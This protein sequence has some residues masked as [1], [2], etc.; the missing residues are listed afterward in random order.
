MSAPSDASE[1]PTSP[2]VRALVDRVFRERAGAMVATLTRILGA[3]HLDLAEDVVQDALLQALRVWSFEGPPSNPSAWL[4]QVA[5]NRALDALRRD[6]ILQSKEPELRRWAEEAQAGES[7]PRDAAAPDELGD[8]RLRLMFVCCHDALSFDA[9]VALTLKT[10]GGF[11]VAEIARAFLAE[12]ATIAQRLVRAKRRIQELALPFEVPPPAELPPRLDAVLDVLYLLFNEGYSATSGEELI[13]PE[14]VREAIRLAELLAEFPPTRTPKVHALLALMLLQGARLPARTDEAGDLLLLAD[15]DRA[16]WDRTMIQRGF[17]AL[18]RAAAGESISAFHLEA[19]IAASHALAPSLAATDWPRILE[20]YDQL[21][22]LS[23]SPVVALNRVVAVAHVDGPAAAMEQLAPLADD[24]SL[25]LYS[26]LHATRGELLA[27]LG[28]KCEAAAALRRA[29][30]LTA[31]APERRLLE[32]R[33]KSCC[34]ESSGWTDDGGVAR[35][36]GS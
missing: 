9:R 29:I 16:R 10:V 30:E 25:A 24:P 36:S 34:G 32:R 28:R 6:R 15:Q 5:R 2:A 33:L 23:P 35:R 8:D 12:E 4:I 7:P 13:R 19:G 20:L 11:T 17:A 14:L 27:R 3:D 22:E 1:P 18:D 21:L 31:S 26:L